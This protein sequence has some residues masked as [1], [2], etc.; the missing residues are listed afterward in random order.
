MKNLKFKSRNAFT[1]VELIVYVAITTMLVVTM[2]LF[3]IRMLDVRKESEFD[4]EVVENARFVLDLISREI[5]DAAGVST[6][7]FGSHP[8]SITLTADSGTVVIDTNTKSVR[9]KTITYIQVNTG[10]G[11]VQVTSD[12]VNITNF[13]LMDLTRGS[14]PENIQVELSLESFDAAASGTFRTAISLRQ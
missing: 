7:T 4:R 3:V 14:E 10:T 1:F 6:G 9:D 2:M 8:G 12:N 13:V 5:H 11:A